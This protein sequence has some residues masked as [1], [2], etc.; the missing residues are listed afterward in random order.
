MAIIIYVTAHSFRLKIRLKKFSFKSQQEPH[1]SYLLKHTQNLWLAGY[2]KNTVINQSN[3]TSLNLKLISIVYMRTLHPIQYIRA[4]F[5]GEKE[6]KAHPIIVILTEA[7]KGISERRRESSANFEPTFG[8]RS[9]CRLGK[10][11]VTSHIRRFNSATLSSPQTLTVYSLP[12]HFTA[13]VNSS[14]VTGDTAI[15]ADDES[16]AIIF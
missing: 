7:L 15:A 11:F 9:F 5:F 1:F 3:S 6:E 2:Q 12:L 13:S 4:R 16:E 14:A 8:Y 10:T